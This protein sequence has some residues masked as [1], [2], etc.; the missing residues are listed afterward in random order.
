MDDRKNDDQLQGPSDVAQ[1]VYETVPVEESMQAEEVSSNVQATDQ[2]DFSQIEPEIAP[3]E[4]TPPPAVATKE[5]NKIPFIIGGVVVFLSVFIL[6]FA[7]L[8]G[9]GK[10]K[11]PVQKQVALSYW[12]LWEEKEVM[13]PLIKEY[14]KAHP[15]VIITYE[16]KTEQDYRQKLLVWIQKGQGPDIFRFHN[17]WIPEIQ[18]VVSAIPESVMS[19]S[20]F[21]KTFYPI[22]TKD[23]KFGTKVY[24]MPLMVDG[25]VLIVNEDLLRK[26]GI[27]T[28]PANWDDMMAAALQ[29]TVKDKD[30]RIITAGFAAGTASN[31]AHFSDIFGLML[32]LNGGDLT[33][34]DMPEASGALE[35]YRRFAEEPNNVWSEDLPNS[36]SAFTQGKVAMIFAPSW[37]IHTIRTNAPDLKIAVAPIPAPPGGKQF[38]L[39]SYWV[40]G[41]SRKSENQ[42]EAW[43]F[44]AYLASKEGETKLYEIQSSVRAFGA[45]YSRMDLADLLVQDQYLG[46]VVKQAAEDR[47]LS[48]P[49]S[50]NTYDDGLNDEIVRYLENAINSASQGVSYTEAMATAKKGIDQVFLRYKIQ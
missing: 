10:K 22:H 40:E 11:E 5:I 14:Q 35:A 20:D 21:E 13:D 16:K 45:T 25:L 38:S 19:V 49:L 24:G 47:F 31:V 46:P 27:A 28:I 50:M 44:L 23:L 33:K 18:E 7:L 2:G 39:A 37:E 15:N 9:S 12:G 29:T 36:I 1:P 3:L 8:A 32:I 43:K 34:L 26:A 4:A 41:V 6:I 30:S 17:T 48:L 42:E